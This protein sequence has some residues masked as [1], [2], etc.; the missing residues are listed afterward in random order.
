[1]LRQ[2]VF[3]LFV[4]TL[5]LS[6]FLFTININVMPMPLSLF[7]HH[8]ALAFALRQPLRMVAVVGHGVASPLKSASWEQVMLHTVTYPLKFSFLQLLYQIQ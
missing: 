7:P 1:M 8:H 3:S 6:L 5:S 4:V 2:S